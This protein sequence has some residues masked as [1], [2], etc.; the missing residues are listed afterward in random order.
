MN[1][2]RT[3]R[4]VNGTRKHVSNVLAGEFRDVEEA[5]ALIQQFLSR[6]KYSRGFCLNLLAHAKNDKSTWRLRQLAILMLEHEIL[7]L[8]TNQ[9]REFDF[10]FRQLNLKHI[11]GIDSPVS[12][13][14][15]KEGYSTT[16]M[17]GFIAEFRRKLERLNRVHRKI[18]GLKT[19]AVALRNFV[20]AAR[21][22][23]KLALARYLFSPQETV[24]QILRHL[25]LT[26]GVRDLDASNP[27]WDKEHLDRVIG[28]LP[29][30]EGTILRQLCETAD[31]YWV[32]NST[33]SEINSLLEYP[34]TTVVLVI[35][36]PGSDIE[37]EI[38]RAGRRGEQA[39]SVVYHRRGWAVPPSHRL[40]GGIS[41]WM[42]QYEASAGTRLGGMYRLVHG[43]EPPIPSY[44]S[45]STVYSVPG[46]NGGV[47]TIPFFTD[48]D[49]FGT[50]F[51]EMRVAM[52]RSVEAYKS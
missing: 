28:M 48:P 6:S 5:H 7:K 45:R 25:K 31:I 33:S 2:G 4:V 11:I 37:F 38:K 43:A 35:K 41:V 49:I 14:V 17:P 15:L 16:D 12:S 50:G 30:Y 32:S 23:C 24:E 44:V 39:L 26:G 52:K 29:D 8:K 18:A 20:E 9:L 36:P 10:W 3:G 34:L 40:D 19:S 21:H 13:S 51:P 42:L 47:S 27:S 46:G 22:P 1:N